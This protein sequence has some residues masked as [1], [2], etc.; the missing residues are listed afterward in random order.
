V[1]VGQKQSAGGDNAM[2]QMNPSAR[3]ALMLD[4]WG[5]DPLSMV[6]GDRGA[7][8]QWRERLETGGKGENTGS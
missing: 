2:R 8:H 7:I 6:G 3:E 1:S 5:Q 4:S